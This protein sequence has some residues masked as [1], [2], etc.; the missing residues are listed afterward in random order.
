MVGRSLAAYCGLDSS[1]VKELKNSRIQEFKNAAM[2]TSAQNCWLFLSS[3]SSL[4]SG[5]VFSPVIFLKTPI[6][7]EFRSNR[8]LAELNSSS[9]ES[10]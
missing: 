10:G 6:A 5:Q 7:Q 2:R 1:K 8:L 9:Y 4:C 3:G